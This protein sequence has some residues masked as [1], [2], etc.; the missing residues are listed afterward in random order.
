MSISVMK[1]LMLGTTV[2]LVATMAVLTPASARGRHHHH[3]HHHFRAWHGPV[4][5]T[6]GYGGCGY[7]YWKWKHTG[8]RYWKSKYVA[9]IY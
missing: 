9:C 4:V 6:S 2:G 3:G 7:Y 8:S 1:K 5:V